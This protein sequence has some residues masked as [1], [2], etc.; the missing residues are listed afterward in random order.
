[1]LTVAIV[2]RTSVGKSTLFNRLCGRSI[3]IVSG[4]SEVSRDRNESIGH[5]GPREFL[6]VDTAGWEDSSSSGSLAQRMR[7][8][9]E[10][11]IAGADVCLFMVDGRAG[12]TALDI[13]LGQRLRSFGAAVILVVNK[14]DG[15][16]TKD[17]FVDEFYRL[18]FRPIVCISAEHG[19]GLNLLYDSL[20]PHEKE[21]LE[22]NGNLANPLDPKVGEQIDDKSPIQIAI[23][24]QPNVGKSTL[25]NHLLGQERLLVGPEAGITRDSIALDW[26]YGGRKIRIMDTAGIRKKHRAGLDLEKFSVAKSIRALNY[27]QVVI[28]VLDATKHPEKQVLSLASRVQEEGRGVLFALNKWDMVTNK[29]KQLRSITMILNRALPA[30]V[31]CPIV[32]I[33]AT[34]GTNLD[35]LM[36]NALGVF[37]SWSSRIST[38]RLNRWLRTIGSENPPPLFRGETTRLKYMSQIKTRPPTF[39]LFT[40]SPERLEETFY[41][42]F[43]LNRLRTDF[44]L[45]TTP[46]RLLLRKSSNPYAS[47]PRP[48]KRR[49]Q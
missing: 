9:S 27:A 21:Y 10:I 13:S 15:R 2:G 41:H 26:Q 5:I 29:N 22:R 32:P 48:K 40:N 46:I 19:E 43:L 14:C 37:E 12:L 47:K 18:G 6:V 35:E 3:A 38:G 17:T 11:A 20:E 45:G 28:L 44:S 49:Q 30:L 36:G 34:D 25:I 8:Q 23:L 4:Q 16:R 33:S 24:G 39:A 42:R 1:M 31:G 7:E